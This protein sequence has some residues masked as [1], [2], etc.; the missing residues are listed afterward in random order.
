M[1][2]KHWNSVILG[3]SIPVDEIE[4]MIDYSYGLVVRKLKKVEREALKLSY[5]K[6][7]LYRD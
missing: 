2:K 7:F 4:K 5:G 1:N 6:D 3:G